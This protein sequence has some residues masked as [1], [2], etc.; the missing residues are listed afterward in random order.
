MPDSNE[1]TTPE[2]EQPGSDIRKMQETTRA[3]LEAGLDAGLPATEA[4]DISRP[5]NWSN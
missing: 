4:L 5:R 2:P 1:S 3:L